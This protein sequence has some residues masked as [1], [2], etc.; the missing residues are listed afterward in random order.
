MQGGREGGRECEEGEKVEKNVCEEAGEK[1]GKTNMCL[2]HLMCTY[3]MYRCD[4]AG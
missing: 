2:L 3:T 1:G 4:I